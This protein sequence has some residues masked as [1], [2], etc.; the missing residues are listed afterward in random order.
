[1]LLFQSF[2]PSAEAA[3]HVGY[4]YLAQS[5]W[6]WRFS[7]GRPWLWLLPSGFSYRRCSIVWAMQFVAM[8]G[9]RR[10]DIT[11][12]SD[13]LPDTLTPIGWSATHLNACSQPAASGWRPRWPNAMNQN[14]MCWNSSSA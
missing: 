3:R 2:T 13:R 8:T 5:A 12:G 7:K 4:G 10:I 9:W 11:E 6:L 14:N 1:M